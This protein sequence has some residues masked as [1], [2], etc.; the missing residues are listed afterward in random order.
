MLNERPAGYW[1]QGS[2]REI[3]NQK[4]RRESWS[5]SVELESL[6]LCLEVLGYKSRDTIAGMTPQVRADGAHA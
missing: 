3:A 4:S 6:L 1:R 2:C 5:I